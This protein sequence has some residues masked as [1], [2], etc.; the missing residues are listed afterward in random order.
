MRI[1]H[2]APDGYVRHVVMND[3]SAVFF[4]NNAWKSIG[5]DLVRIPRQHQAPF[6]LCLFM[7]V[8]T[9][10]CLYT[11]FKDAYPTWR[12]TTNYPKF[13]WAYCR[14]HNENPFKLLWIPEHK[15]LLKVSDV[16]ELLPAFVSFMLS[17]TTHYLRDCLPNVEPVKFFECI[18]QDEAYAFSKGLIVAGFKA[19]FEK[20]RPTL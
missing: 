13:G 5:K 8:L 18:Y 10:Q 7:I 15:N 11:Y 3:E 1:E 6:I 16:T 19:E 14:P 12:Q 4:G 2:H 17:E 9:D 20:Q